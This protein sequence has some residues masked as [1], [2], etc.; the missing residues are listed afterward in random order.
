M[1]IPICR[2]LTGKN[3]PKKKIWTRGIFPKLRLSLGDVIHFNSYPDGNPILKVINV[4]DK[5]RVTFMIH[6]RLGNDI[7]ITGNSVS[8]TGLDEFMELAKTGIS[9]T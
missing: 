6:Q 1:I 7:S 5:E 8:V 4:D 2:K 3:G 9:P